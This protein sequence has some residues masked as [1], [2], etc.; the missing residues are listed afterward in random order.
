[1]SNSRV[2]VDVP[3]FPLDLVG[4]LLA[5]TG[6]AVEASPP[7]LRG[8]DVAGLLV[9]GSTVEEEDFERLPSL[10]VVATSSVGYDHI[11]VDAAARRGV[12]VCNVP[13]YCIEEMA[14][15]TLALALA[16]LRGIVF[17]DRGVRS[18]RWDEHAGGALRRI[19]DTRF[20]VIG[21]GRIGRAVARRAVGAGFEVW[22]FDPLVPA[23]EIA[24][25]GAR[26]AELEELLP[27]CHLVTLHVPLTT[28]TEGMI[29]E[30]ELG[31]MP[32]G[33][34]LVDTARAGLLDWPAFRR[35]LEDGR[36]AAAAVD[37]L[38]VEPPTPEHPVPDLPNLIVTPHSAWYSPEAE[39]AIYRRP[40]LSVR[41]VLEG[42]EPDGAVVRPR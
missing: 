9:W 22:A 18:G 16:L 1:M 8:D 29:G 12:W 35:A 39:E 2:L 42:R 26:P 25:L 3:P 10:K 4:D 32:R 14:D 38:P 19:R 20:G 28:E 21:C 40:T 27:A 7:L 33:S 13:D 36:L 17:Y 6:V 5:G 30:R 23:E 11:D 37:V 34:F 15:S 31:L 41:A 24:A